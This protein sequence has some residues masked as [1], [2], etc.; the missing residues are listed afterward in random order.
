MLEADGAG[1]EPDCAAALTDVLTRARGLPAGPRSRRMCGT[2]LQ[3]RGD[4]SRMTLFSSAH[5]TA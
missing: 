4:G 3:H 2:L 1:M 5:K